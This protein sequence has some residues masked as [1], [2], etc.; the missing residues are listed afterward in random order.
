MHAFPDHLLHE[1]LRVERIL[2]AKV[3]EARLHPDPMG[4]RPTDRVAR[5]ASADNDL[6]LGAP[7][8]A[9]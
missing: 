6:R 9:A 2:G 4:S 3:D 7:K 5:R 8:L 1:H